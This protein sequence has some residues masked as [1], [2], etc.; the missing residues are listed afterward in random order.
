MDVDGPLAVLGCVGHKFI[1]DQTDQTDFIGAYPALA[2]M[3]VDGPTED[4]RQ[5]RAQPFHEWPAGNLVVRFAHVE[6]FVHAGDRG[7]TLRGC[8]QF[9][10]RVAQIRSPAL[11]RKQTRDELKAVHHT[12]VDLTRH[13]VG[14][15]CRH[16]R[17]QAQFNLIHHDRCEVLEIGDLVFRDRPGRAIDHAERA[18][19]EPIASAQWNARLKTQTEIS[20]HERVCK[21]IGI[22]LGV[23]E[24][25]RVGLEDGRSAQSRV[26]ADLAQM[27]AE[28]AMKACA[29][30]LGVG[31]PELKELG[32]RHAR[33]AARL[34]ALKPHRDGT[35]VS[36]V[37]RLP[38]YV[39]SRYQA[40]GMTRLDVVHLALGVQFVAASTV[41][42]LTDRDLALEMERG[43]WP[44]PRAPLV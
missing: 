6:I 40:A 24:Y 15:L 10:R 34:A 13:D 42:R 36:T 16:A 5:V 19:I 41:R 22:C 18:K 25:V 37:A 2:D 39:G 30:H 3:S 35:L 11:H 1:D 14:A 8:A 33:L 38:S 29:A 28:L 9:F 44:G 26:A 27:T 4:E 43:S 23:Q 21:G 31:A 7:D 17:R 12:V 32:H 20:G